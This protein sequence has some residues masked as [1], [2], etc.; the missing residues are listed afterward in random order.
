M[1]SDRLDSPLGSAASGDQ[2]GGPGFWRGSSSR[3]GDE[4]GECYCGGEDI[5]GEREPRD[6]AVVVLPDSQSLKLSQRPT[7][8]RT[9]TEYE[10][11]S[12][13]LLKLR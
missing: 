6:D 2:G 5:G 12:G 9:C 10:P 11:C 13:F 3:L 8:I 7:Y 4:V 1:I